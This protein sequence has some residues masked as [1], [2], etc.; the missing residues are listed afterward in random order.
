MSISSTDGRGGP[1]SLSPP[2]PQ[3]VQGPPPDPSRVAALEAALNLP[4]PLCALLVARGHGQP[5][6]AKTFLRPLLSGLHPPETLPD[7]PQAVSRILAAIR[8]KETILVH[9]DY[10]V[11]GMAGTALLARF[12]ERLGARVVPFLPHRLRDGYDLSKSGLEAAVSAG[13]SLVVTVDCGILAHEAVKEARDL[14][15]DVIITDHHTPGEDLPPALAVVNPAREDS[16]YPNRDLCG[17]G[18]AFK[19]CQGLARA[20]EIP[21]DELHP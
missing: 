19:L 1:G 14:G 12:L 2:A 13:A 15:L 3:W 11:D 9:G 4:R 6:E 18:V 7:L 5:E 10:D 17:T 21:E 20:R 8:G 16:P